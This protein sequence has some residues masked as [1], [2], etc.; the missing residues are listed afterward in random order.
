MISRVNAL[1]RLDSEHGKLFWVN[2]SKYHSEKSGKEAGGPTRNGSGKFYWTIKIDGK[3][4]KRGRLVFL[5]VNGRWP[6]PCVDHIN[7]NSLDDRPSNLREAT[8]QENAM[9]HK[10]RTKKSLLPMGVKA[11]KYRRYS[12]RISYKNRQFH[13]GCYDTP[14][15][16]RAVYLAKRKELFREFA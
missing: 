16:A 14:E 4:Y 3:K 11:L 6:C 7:G 12:A 1:L 15:E 5:I 13:L 9:N 10:R 2:P 8:V